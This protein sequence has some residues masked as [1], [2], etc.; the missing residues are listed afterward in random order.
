MKKSHNFSKITART[1]LFTVLLSALLCCDLFA[2]EPNTPPRPPHGPRNL[3]D[4]YAKN[5]DSWYKSEEGIRIANNILSWQSPSGSWPKNISTTSE[6]FTA[7]PNSLEGTFDNNA[8]TNEIR[9]LARAFLAAKDNRYKQA[10]LKGIDTILKAQYPNGGWPQ[11]YPLRSNYS[12][13]ITF[14]DNCMVNLMNLLRDVAIS[15]N[16]DFIDFSSR[17]TAQRS[18]DR[19]VDCILNCQIKVNGKL[20]IWCAQHDEKTLAPQ[21]ARSYELASLSGSESKGVL[22]LLMSLDN[23]SPKVIEAI[24]TGAKWF[25]SSKITGIRLSRTSEDRAV[26]LDPNAPPIWARFYEI[27][28]SRDGIKK[29]SLAEIEQERRAH[30]AWYG[31]WGKDVAENYAKW[32]QKNKQ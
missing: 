8:T 32:K 30:Y 7:D 19:G 23:P 28:T 15:P 5:P 14:N 25:D 27:E 26:E 17:N 1:L 11:Y 29:Y 16:F 10:V 2:A 21:L 13:H 3:W 6:P 12:R 22:D 9:F 31:Y 20:T 18:F 24:K 4:Q